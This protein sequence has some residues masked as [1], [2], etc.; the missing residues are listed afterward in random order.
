MLTPEYIDQLILDKKTEGKNIEFKKSKIDSKEIVDYCACFANAGGGDLLFGVN[1]DGSIAGTNI[2]SGTIHQLPNKFHQQFDPFLWIDVEE[3]FHPKGRVVIFKI[4]SRTTGQIIRSKGNYTYPVRKGSSLIEMNNEDLRLILNET[5]PDYTAEIMPK[6]NHSHLDKTAIEIFRQKWAEHSKK[7]EYKNFSDEAILRAAN[8]LTD[9][10]FTVAALILFGTEGALRSHLPSYEIIFE[11]RQIPE[12]NSHDFRKEWRNAFLLIFDDI[13]KTISDRNIRFPFQDGF[14]QKEV[15]A[16]NEKVLREAILNATAHRDYRMNRSSIF[17]KASP[18]SF[19]IESPGGF[20]A[21]VNAE[22]AIDKQSSRNLLLCEAFQ[23]IHFVERA[24][25]GVDDI[26]TLCIREGKGEPNFDG[27]DSY[28]V[29]LNIPATLE[30]AA[31]VQFLE[32]IS[33]E[34]QFL[35]STKEILE[36]EKIRIHDGIK[37]ISNKRKLVDDLG[38]VEKIGHGRGTKYIMSHLYYKNESKTAKYTK[39]AGIGRDLKKELII[40]YITKD[41]KGYSKHIQNQLNLSSIE[42]R[43]LLAELK[44]AGK[45]KCLGKGSQAHWILNDASS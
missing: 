32:K 33:N 40:K 6:I 31:F 7:L 14:F 8:L 26:F 30:D 34:K 17:I 10:G 15:W 24:G 36:L 44:S 21:G 41:G 3:V 28:Q 16:F 43:N 19:R 9:Q 4:P 39:L 2:Y 22:N 1:D 23:R 20:V 13:W 12:K 18:K 42:S 37:E 35:L 29:A 5:E 45:I 38:I 27:S 25:Q 11:W